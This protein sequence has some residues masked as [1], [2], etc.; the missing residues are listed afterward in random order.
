MA[1]TYSD[2]LRAKKTKA[3]MNL[4]ATEIHPQNPTF[5]MRHFS[6]RAAA[7]LTALLLASTL[8][9]GLLTTSAAAEPPPVSRTEVHPPDAVG[10]AW[11]FAIQ[12]PDEDITRGAELA[13]QAFYKGAMKNAGILVPT[14]SGQAVYPG[15]LHPYDNYWMNQVTSYFFARES[16]EWPIRLFAVY[17]SPAG[18]IQ[19]GVYQIPDSDWRRK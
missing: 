3:A 19:G 17:Q 9:L 15:W 12:T 7:H 6:T 16:T 8:C 4:S 10:E 14:V 1:N 18:E 2:L 11:R 5:V 13:I